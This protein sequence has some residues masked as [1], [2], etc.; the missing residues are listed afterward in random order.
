[1][2][3]N[4]AQN[5]PYGSETEDAR[6]VAVE[7]A[8]AAFEGLRDKVAAETTPLGDDPQDDNVE[9]RRWWTWVCPAD[10][11]KGRLHVSGYALEKRAVY[12]VCDTCGKTFIR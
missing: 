4:I 1:M 10:D 12:T 2:S 9:G 8:F 5:F 6:A 3:S 7:K 11:F